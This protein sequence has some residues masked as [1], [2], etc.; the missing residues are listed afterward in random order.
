MFIATFY[1]YIKKMSR[2]LF[3]LSEKVFKKV[4]LGWGGVG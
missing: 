4:F 3:E 2:D 1:Y